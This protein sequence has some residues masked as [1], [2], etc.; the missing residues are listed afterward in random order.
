MKKENII[1]QNQVELNIPPQ[2]IRELNESL[3]FSKD[4]GIHVNKAV[5]EE[6]TFGFEAVMTDFFPSP[7]LKIMP[8]YPSIAV[9]DLK[10]R[11]LAYSWFKKL[12]LHDRQDL[13]EAWYFLK[14]LCQEIQNP[15]ARVLGKSM[16]E[17]P[18]EIS[19]PTLEKYREDILEI[20][21]KPSAPNRIRNSLW[22]N[23]THQVKKSRKTM[24][25][26]KD[27]NDPTSLET[28]IS[29]LTVLEEEAIRE[30]IFFGTSPI[31][32]KSLL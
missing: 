21:E 30:K 19:T 27:P 5:V 18:I 32:F 16:A 12:P 29:E 20:L 10:R 8:G 3:L 4:L 25:E 26:I 9:W 11:A 17:L 14:F 13:Y 23:Y 22:K 2:V 28:L 1:I 15:V 31:I 24:E 6:E 7:I